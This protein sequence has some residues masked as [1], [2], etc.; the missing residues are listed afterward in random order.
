MSR[1]RFKY[2]NL[3]SISILTI[4]GFIFVAG[5]KSPD[6]IAQ[7]LSIAFSLEE[8][9]YMD[10]ESRKGQQG[11]ANYSALFSWSRSLDSISKQVSSLTT[12]VNK[13]DASD[14]AAFSTQLSDLRKSIDNLLSKPSIAEIDIASWQYEDA[15]N[16][17]TRSDVARAEIASN[18]RQLYNTSPASTKGSFVKVNLDSSLYDTFN[19]CVAL[20]DPLTQQIDRLCNEAAKQGCG[21]QTDIACVQKFIATYPKDF[22][23]KGCS[24]KIAEDEVSR[25]LT[26]VV[27]QWVVLGIE[28]CGSKQ[29][30]RK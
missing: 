27:S 17:V 8:S 15:K 5:C 29:P 12:K 1:S 7:E 3:Y 6:D 28:A 26:S 24:H 22:A 21:H 11:E 25:R 13:L 23:T 20:F 14:R 9:A 19:D 16:A 10:L 4:A 2:L 30:I 18:Y